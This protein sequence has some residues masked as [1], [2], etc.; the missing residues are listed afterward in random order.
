MTP[1]ATS[2]PDR[3]ALRT[4]HRPLLLA[5]PRLLLLSGSERCGACA[6]A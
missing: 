1:N 3:A 5:L 6:N 4:A 2:A